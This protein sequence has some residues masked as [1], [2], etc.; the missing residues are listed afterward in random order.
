MT[1]IQALEYKA[2]AIVGT[3]AIFSGL[4]IEY[5]IWNQVF[6]SQGASEIRG[7]TFKGLMAYIFLCM[8]VGQLKSSWATSI[9]MIDSIR[10]GEL[11]KYL[12]NNLMTISLEHKCKFC[13]G[14]TVCRLNANI[15][16]RCFFFPK[17]SGQANL[18]GNERESLVFIDFETTGLEAGK[19]HLI[20][21]G[22]LKIDEE[23]FEHTF[24]TF[25][26]PPVSLSEKI[27]KITNITD[28]MLINAPTIDKV[29]DDLCTFI[30]ESTII[31]HN[32]KF[33]V[34]WLLIESNKKGLAFNAN[35]IICTFEWATLLKESK[36]SL[37]ALTKKYKVGHLNSHRALADAAATKELFFIFE[38]FQTIARPTKDMS[39]YKEFVQRLEEK[40]RSKKIV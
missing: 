35:T 18:F 5:L 29:I 1:W 25:V 36:C 38:N 22:A 16:H 37:S 27:T 30:S 21:I 10:T 39:V 2:N 8:V 14:P 33:D 19:D 13:N 6:E 26:K 32:A 23:G 20:E 24:D 3:F 40:R 34:S 4:I 11:N 12:I 28:E 15:G 17:C 31:A 7:F 9:D